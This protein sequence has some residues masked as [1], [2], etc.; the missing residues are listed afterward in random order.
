MFINLM[1]VYKK[2]TTSVIYTISGNIHSKIKPFRNKKT[3]GCYM[4]EY[5]PRGSVMSINH[6]YGDGTAF[7]SIGGVVQVNTLKGNSGIFASSTTLDNF[8]LPT[9]PDGLKEVYTDFTAILCTKTVTAVL[10]VDEK[11]LS[12]GLNHK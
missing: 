2:D 6:F 8:F 1:T 11:R 4:A 5:F 3:L 10:P 12:L 7:N 9:L